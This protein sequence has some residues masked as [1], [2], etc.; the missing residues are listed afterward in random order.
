MELEGKNPV[1]ILNELYPGIQYQ[2]ISTTG[3]S[4]APQFIIKASLN[5]MSFEGS[6]KSKKDAKLNASKALLVHLHK[7]GFDP[8]TGDMMSTQVNNDDVAEGHTFADLIGKVVT[9]KYQALFGTTTYSKRR[10]M[11]GIVMTKGGNSSFC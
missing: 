10:V 4:H 9:A 1:S 8:M 3:P 2:L 6:G 5:D 11:S 7:V